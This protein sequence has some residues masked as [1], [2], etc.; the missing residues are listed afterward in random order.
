MAGKTRYAVGKVKNGVSQNAEFDAIHANSKRSYLRRLILDF[1]NERIAIGNRHESADIDMLMENGITAVLNVAYDLDISYFEDD[2][3]AY[4]FKIEYHKA[5]MID[6]P[7]NEATTLAAAAYLLVQILERHDKVFV[8][9]HAGVSR[10]PTVVST[11][12]AY[13]QGISFDEA[14]EAV[15]AKRTAANPNTHLRELAR[16]VLT[17]IVR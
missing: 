12:L 15:K 6:G 7:G 3:P 13:A 1:V 14:L 4:K 16:T 5:G 11:Y 9:C 10:A 8:H 2:V 17:E